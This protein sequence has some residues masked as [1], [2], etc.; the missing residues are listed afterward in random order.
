MSFGDDFIFGLVMDAYQFEGKPQRTE[1]STLA[2]PI[3]TWCH[4]DMSLRKPCA[5]KEC[6]D[7]AAGFYDRME[8]DIA[9]MAGLEQ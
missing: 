8:D 4:W 1:N 5:W 2:F 7:V 6:G 9:L 3:G